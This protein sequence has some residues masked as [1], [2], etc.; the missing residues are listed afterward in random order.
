MH[1][2]VLWYGG[3][4]TVFGAGFGVYVVVELA[5]VS[6]MWSMRDGFGQRHSWE[7]KRFLARNFR[8][9]IPRLARIRPRPVPYQA[10]GSSPANRARGH[11]HYRQNR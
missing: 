7:P 11:K 2:K 9:I 3:V 8:P 1:L 6:M 4:N 10:S 5:G